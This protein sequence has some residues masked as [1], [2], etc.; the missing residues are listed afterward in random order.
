MSIATDDELKRVRAQYP[1]WA[2][3]YRALSDG[4]AP[5]TVRTPQRV[6]DLARQLANGQN[7]PY[8]I[9]AATERYLRTA[10]TY[11]TTVPEPPPN[12]DVTDYFLFTTK[13]GYCEYYA[14][15]MTVLLRADGIPARVVNG[16]LPGVR[17]ADGRWLSRESQAHAWVEVYFPGYG[18]ITFDPTPRPDVP[19][20]KRNGPM[21]PAPLPTPTPAPVP[22]AAAGAAAPTPTPP[23]MNDPVQL[24]RPNSANDGPNINP[25]WFFG[26][27]L[28][29]GFFGIIA[30][31]VAWWWLA[32]LRGLRLGA[33]WYFRLQRSAGLLGG[34]VNR[35]PPRRM[36]LRRQWARNS[37]PLVG[38][39]P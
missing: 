34:P 7:G 18:W 4:S 27:L 24:A 10:Y 19:P 30:G 37:P 1:A 35:K 5:G 15:A 29:L 8:E 39:R 14:T 6:R 12:T 13:Q 32:P 11:A 26:P 38:P 2:D 20:I 9:A 17:Q 25:W 28:A 16:Y 23:P 22:E 3:R 21:M 31:A 33:R 36:S